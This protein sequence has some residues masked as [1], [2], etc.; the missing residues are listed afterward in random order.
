MLP[1]DWPETALMLGLISLGG[2]AS[3]L[4]VPI[5]PYGA[6]NLSPIVFLVAASAY[7]KEVAVIIAA[8]CPLSGRVVQRIVGMR[9]KDPWQVVAAGGEAA[10]ALTLADRLV[11]AFGQHAPFL[12]L[13]VLSFFT[14]LLLMCLTALR[15]LFS[16]RVSIKRLVG[17]LARRVSPHLLAILATIPI[18]WMT[19][20]LIG[21]LGMALAVV[22]IVETYYP[23]KLLGEQRDLFL[24][25]LQMMSNAVDL[26]D[27]YTAHHSKR[28]AEV[29]VNI[30]RLLGATEEEVQRIRVGALMHD[31]GKIGVS[32]SIIRKP[33]KLTHEEMDL[34]KGH[35]EA[36]ARLMEGLEI[37]EES[38]PI[39]LH[40][41]ENYNGSGYPE[42]LAGDNIPL[43]SRIVFVA[44]AFDALTTDRPY[45]KG[46]SPLEAILVIKENAGS[47]FDPAVV[48]A[49]EKLI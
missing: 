25:S 2:L 19:F 30:A 12:G 6:L 13:I 36:G 34:M 44:D 11:K 18:V 49:F 5:E 32:G 7:G 24:R 27:P 41:H 22:V 29:S 28:V 38:A 20:G 42:G 15:I 17:P 35:V 14:L 1:L 4:E 8:L 47:Q 16:E 3:W 40:H 48:T 33:A 31:I 23:W 39:V 26:K 45:R 21:A 43:G 46:R 37:L 10:L 9:P